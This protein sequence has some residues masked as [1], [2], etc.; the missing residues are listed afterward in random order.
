M[1]KKF[2]AWL[3]AEC[4]LSPVPSEGDT[5]TLCRPDTP[6]SLL[7]ELYEKVKDMD[8]ESAGDG[9]GRIDRW[10]S[11]EFESLLTRVKEHLS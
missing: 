8:D 5:C 7:R 2:S 4:W 1:N 10:Q 11:S 9:D 3:C 6:T